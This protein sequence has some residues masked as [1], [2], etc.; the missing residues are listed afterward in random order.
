MRIDIHHQLLA[1]RHEIVARGLLPAGKRWGMRVA[2][3][4]LRFTWLYALA[5][6]V[7]RFFLRVLPPAWTRGLSGAWG[8]QRELP[9]VPPESFRE[10]YRRT[11]G[12]P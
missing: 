12:Q 4:V 10:M 7:A 3:W 9:V 8:R 1:W 6:R 2:S 5:G 11:R